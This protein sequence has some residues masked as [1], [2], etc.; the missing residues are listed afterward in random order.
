MSESIY[1]YTLGDVRNYDKIICHC[2]VTRSKIIFIGL[3]TCEQAALV[4][5]GPSLRPTLDPVGGLRDP[6]I[7]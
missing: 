7:F 4:C 3:H 2:G 6:E 5:R 1:Q